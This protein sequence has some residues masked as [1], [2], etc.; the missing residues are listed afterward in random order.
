MQYFKLFTTEKAQKFGQKRQGETKLFEDIVFSN[1]KENLEE[2]I[3]K[4]TAKFVLFGISEDIGVQANY[5]NPGTKHAWNSVI[6][7]LLNIQSNRFTMT[8]DLMILGH[9]DF[10]SIENKKLKDIKSLREAVKIIDFEVA[11]LVHLIK[12]YGKIPIAIGGGHNNAYGLIKGCSLALNNK[13]NVI[14]FDAHSDL[15]ALEGR[16]SGNG[17]SYALEDG[18]LN[19]YYIFGLHENYTPESIFS[20]IDNS[21]NI[22]FISYESVEVKKEITFEKALDIGQKFVSK[23]P[24]GIEI[25]CDAIAHCPSSAMTPTGF[26]IAEVRKFVFEIGKNTNTTYLHICEAAPKNSHKKRDYNVGKMIS[27]LIM[28]F[29]RAKKQNN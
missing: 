23:N 11:H 26:S 17:F 14:N 19:R 16:H 15:R 22:Q 1:P 27:A 12:K 6:N 24:F 2:Q 7:S 28:D 21:K 29:I 9:F 10:N 5:G 20:K 3:Q 25:D 4:S 18:F 8:N 13:I